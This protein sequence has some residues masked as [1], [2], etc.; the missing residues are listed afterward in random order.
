MFINA[1]VLS[2]VQRSL[3][4]LHPHWISAFK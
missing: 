3:I 4:S 2:V 1:S